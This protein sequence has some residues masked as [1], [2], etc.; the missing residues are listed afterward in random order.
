MVETILQS[1]ILNSMIRAIL[2]SS[3]GLVTPTYWLWVSSR[4]QN[5][6]RELFLLQ[7]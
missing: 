7:K 5:L 1:L 2:A 3:G 6:D 4:I